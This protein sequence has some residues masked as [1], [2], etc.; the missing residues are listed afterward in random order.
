MAQLDGW[1]KRFA[2]R[3]YAKPA[4]EKEEGMFS[5]MRYFVAGLVDTF[6][7][8]F[9]P[10][11][12]TGLE[13][14]PKEGSAIL[15]GN[16]TSFLDIPYVSFTYVYSGRWLYWVARESLLRHPL[17]A[18]VFALFGVIPVNTEKVSP[19]SVIEIFKRLRE[20]KVIG[21]F[22]QGTRCK[23][24]EKLE[25]TPPQTGTIEFA[26]RTNS[27]IVPFAIDSEFKPFRKAKIIY[28]EPYYI[29][30]DKKR[31]SQE[32]SMAEAI[33]L[34]ERIF[35]LLGRDYPLKNKAKL[36]GGILHDDNN[37]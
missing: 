24:K 12:C 17:L 8:I 2:K 36:T 23:T 25:N 18:Y 1:R 31:L 27:P 30:K 20:D 14:I 5:P 29:K 4:P 15:C 10:Y 37:I 21:L 33:L 34:M 22:P 6:M 26:M 35:K 16:H 7:R 28:G 3:Q 19:S 11:E 13:N 9:Y 32:E